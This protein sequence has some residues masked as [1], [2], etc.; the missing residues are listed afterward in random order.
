MATISR[1]HQ[2][3]GSPADCYAG[4]ISYEKYPDYLPGVVKIERIKPHSAKAAVGLR[5]ELN[6]IKTFYYILDM[7]HKENTEVK[8]QLVDSNLMTKNSGLWLLKPAG[9]GKTNATYQLEVDFKGLVPSA[10]IKKITE[11]SMPGMIDGFQRL[12]HDQSKN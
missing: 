3:D 11:S 2:F 10:I 12:I 6:L 8:W 9:K 5:Y 4:I 1:E 7:Y